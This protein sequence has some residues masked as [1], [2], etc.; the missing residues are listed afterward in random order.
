MDVTKPILGADKAIGCICLRRYTG[1][2]VHRISDIPACAGD[3]DIFYGILPFKQIER[4]I[5]IL[6]PNIRISL[7]KPHLPLFPSSFLHQPI[8]S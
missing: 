4:T 3:D 6:V 7:L 2:M 8:P 5:H 1:G